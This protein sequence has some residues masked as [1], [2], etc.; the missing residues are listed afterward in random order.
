[1][2]NVSRRGLLTLAALAALPAACSRGSSPAASSATAPLPSSTPPSPTPFTASA[3]PAGSVAPAA[4]A[5]RSA[6]PARTA[7]AASRSAS[8]D[9]SR[10]GPVHPAADA[11]ML[12]S[13]LDLSGRSLASSLKL[14]REQLGQDQK[15]VHQFW[16]WD[17]AM[18]RSRPTEMADDA[19]LMISWHGTG[20]SSIT[21]GGSDKLIASAAR[22]LAAQKRPLLLRWGWEMNG[23]WFDWDGSHNGKDPDGYIKVWQRLHRIFADE[24]A[25]NVAWVWSPN[26]NSGPS[27]SWN[28]MQHYY[29]G[30]AYVDW[31]G[32]SGYSFD[33]ESPK[34]LFS[35]IVK[36]YGSRKPIILTETAGIDHGGSS[37]ANWIDA[38]SAYCRKTPSIKAITWF[39]T[40]THNDTNFRID[41][42]SSSLAAYKRMA[43]LDHFQA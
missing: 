39:D 5:T 25:D 16:A 36:L 27:D 6:E 24:G 33:G 7:E 35:P 15:I 38:L 26:W 43:R 34:T 2:S 42:S 14:R 18:P 9:S 8:R 30:D 37:K 22:N 10:G 31:V 1:M 11:V 32:V 28:R 12:G 4:T 23:N 41:S 19:T 13:Y 40:D 3:S 29:P 17:E 21:G 20:W